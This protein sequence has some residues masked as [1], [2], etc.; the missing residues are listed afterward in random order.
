[1]PSC[2]LFSF[3]AAIIAACPIGDDSTALM[4]KSSGSGGSIRR[5]VLREAPSNTCSLVRS[6]AASSKPS[7]VKRTGYFTLSAEEYVANCAVAIFFCWR[8][9]HTSKNSTICAATREVDVTATKRSSGET[10]PSVVLSPRSQCLSSDSCP[11]AEETSSRIA[12]AKETITG[13]RAGVRS[14]RGERPVTQALSA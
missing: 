14:A 10:S 8:K 4:R 11:N 6:A 7:A 2:S 5:A 13:C 9:S 3:Q 12:T 1:M